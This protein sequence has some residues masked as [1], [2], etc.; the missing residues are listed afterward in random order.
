MSRRFFA[1][2]SFEPEYDTMRRMRALGIDTF[3]FM[4]SNATN[5]MGMPYTRY[6][7]TWIWE[8]T[9]DFALFDQNV[10]ELLAGVPECEVSSA[11]SMSI[12]PP[13]GCGGVIA[14]PRGRIRFAN[15]GG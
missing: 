7:P 6:Q 3:T 2:R 5:F 4:V 10:R 1:Y 14:M 15:W 9:Y 12:P 11:R 8:R 13:G